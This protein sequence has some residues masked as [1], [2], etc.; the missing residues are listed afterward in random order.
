[1][2]RKYLL[3]AT[4]DREIVFTEF[5]TECPRYWS[6]EKGSYT[7]E[8]VRQFSASF[9]TVRPFKGDDVDLTEYFENLVDSIDKAEA[10]DLNQRE[11]VGWYWGDYDYN[12]VEYYIKKYY[13]EKLKQKEQTKLNYSKAMDLPI[14]YV[15]FISDCLDVIR[16][17]N[18]YSLLSNYDD[19]VEAA[20]LHLEEVECRFC[21]KLD[22]YGDDAIIILED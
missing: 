5:E 3:G 15:H 8:S 19:A 10:Y 11:L 21:K 22:D 12:D 1:M 20:K 4:A 9:D 7:D 14:A 13:E 17:H 2:R 16:K 6:K 18:L